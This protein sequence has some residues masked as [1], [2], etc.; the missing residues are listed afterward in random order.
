MLEN[1]ASSKKFE[2]SFTFPPFLSAFKCFWVQGRAPLCLFCFPVHF[3]DCTQSGL[4]SAVV[5]GPRWVGDYDTLL[6]LMMAE[7][8]VASPGVSP[9]A[10]VLPPRCT[11][12]RSSVLINLPKCGG[13]R[14]ACWAEALARNHSAWLCCPRWVFGSQDVLVKLWPWLHPV[15][16]DGRVV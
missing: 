2:L 15:R 4:V 3:R 1:L 7:I 6:L 10:L 11:P 12:T 16:Q 9:P 14:G 8:S 5:W 13:H